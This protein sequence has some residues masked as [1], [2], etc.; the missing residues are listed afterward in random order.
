MKLTETKE[1]LSMRIK[2]VYQ[3]SCEAVLARVVAASDSI[4]NESLRVLDAPEKMMRLAIKEAEALAFQTQYPDLVF[5]DLAAEKIAAVA[6]WTEHE[7]IVRGIR[8]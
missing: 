8:A 7:R 6:R 4:L 3:R 1:T 2:N 5:P